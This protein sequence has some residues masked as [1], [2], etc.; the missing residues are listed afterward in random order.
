[1]FLFKFSIEGVDE[2]Q[3]I[4][5]FTFLVYKTNSYERLEIVEEG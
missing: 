3:I 2:K 5:M 1:M 4:V